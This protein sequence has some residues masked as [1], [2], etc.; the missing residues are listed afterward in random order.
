[1]RL[2]TEPDFFASEN[3][4]TLRNTR[5]A[6]LLGLPAISLPTGHP[7]CGLMLMGAAGHDRALLIVA[8]AAE[9]AL[10]A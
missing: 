8:A 3:L 1:N 4:L 9:T 10:Q 7:G 6:N 5:I 2:L